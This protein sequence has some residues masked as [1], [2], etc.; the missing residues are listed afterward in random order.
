M[1]TTTKKRTS[2]IIGVMLLFVLCLFLFFCMADSTKQLRSDSAGVEFKTEGKI[3]TCVNI[4]GTFP[5]T[6][7]VPKL[8]EERKTDSE[9]NITEVYVIEAEFSLN[10]KNTMNLY[11][12]KLE[13]AT[14]TYILKFADKDIIISNGQVVE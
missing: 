10:T 9:G 1:S 12:E 7:I 6:S 11:F 2:L 5:Y 14:Y 3:I 13:N 8:A 4:K